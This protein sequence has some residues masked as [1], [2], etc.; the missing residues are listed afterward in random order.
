MVTDAIFGVLFSGLSALLSLLPVWSLPTA[1]D[2]TGP[3]GSI[4]RAI[5]TVDAVVPIR[6]AATALAASLA[7]LLLLYAWDFLVWVYHQFWGSS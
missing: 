3:L 2:S 5:I 7:L 4:L 6:T 1:T